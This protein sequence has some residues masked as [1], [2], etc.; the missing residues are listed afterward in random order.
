LNPK[1]GEVV[2]EKIQ[3]NRTILEM[4]KAGISRREIA[5]KFGISQIRIQQIEDRSKERIQFAHESSRV[6]EKLK[7]TQLEP[8]EDAVVRLYYNLNPPSGARRKYRRSPNEFYIRISALK[9]LGLLEDLLGPEDLSP[10]KQYLKPPEAQEPLTE[11]ARVLK[12]AQNLMTEKELDTLRRA[13][14]KLEQV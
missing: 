11:E 1:Q 13:F 7:V 6:N 12:K 14:K 2:K 8:E 3:R 10:L 9:K 5:K 4:R